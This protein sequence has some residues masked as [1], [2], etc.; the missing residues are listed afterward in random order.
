MSIMQLNKKKMINIIFYQI[1]Q[2]KIYRLEYEIID[3]TKQLEENAYYLWLNDKNDKND[4]N[5]KKDQLYYF[6]EA[7]KFYDMI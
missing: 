2:L 4:K 6:N 3:R 5:N 1:K 7:L